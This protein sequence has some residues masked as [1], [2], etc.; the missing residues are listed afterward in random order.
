MYFID[1][2]YNSL[3]KYNEE[4]CGDCIQQA[5]LDD[6]KIFVL[7]DGLGSGVKANILSTL[8]SKIAITMLREGATLEET[9]D[10]IVH[11]LPVCKQRHLAYSTFTLIKIYKN[12]EAYAAEFDNPSIFLHKD[13]KDIPI[14]KTLKVIG[15]KN[16]YESR[17]TMDKDTVLVAVSDG[18]VHAGVGH[19]LDLGWEWV[20]VNTY[21]RDMSKDDV[22]TKDVVKNVLDSCMELYEDEPGDDTSVLAV[23]IKEQQVVNLFIGPP[24]DR[25]NDTA[26]FEKVLRSGE[27]VA[28]CGGTTAQIA[29]RLLDREM[30]FDMG[31]MTMD[32]P[33]IAKIE[34]VELVT[35]GVITLSKAIDI[36]REYVKPD[37]NPNIDAKLHENNAAS[38]LAK[39]LIE[40]C[41]SVKIYQ[42]TAINPAHQDL[43]FK[44]DFTFKLNQ[45]NEL[46]RLLMLM[47]KDVEVTY[48]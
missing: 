12:G 19:S 39:L 3:K 24:R 5:N 17:F 37:Y 36:M 6:C 10:T 8:T 46:R 9:I 42:G 22:S 20:N 2:S 43:A 11:T 15:D 33:A 35:E 14:E 21:L 13:G 4:L 40:E 41:D 27:K 25:K 28:I 7:S 23:K 1:A 48:I 32:I 47:G 26:V 44:M 18:V 30:D 34:G 29:S 31:T 16:I 45:M 38:M